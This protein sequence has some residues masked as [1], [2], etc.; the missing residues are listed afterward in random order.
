MNKLNVG[1][2]S[3]KSGISSEIR[4]L[5]VAVRN[6][7]WPKQDSAMDDSSVPL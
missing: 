4:L 2:P 1:Q 6:W 5:P 3:L 7:K